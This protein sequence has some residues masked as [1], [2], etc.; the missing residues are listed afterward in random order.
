MGLPV[1]VVGAG[2][3][4]LPAATA[5]AENGIDVLVF[6][7]GKHVSPTSYPTDQFNYE[8]LASPWLST[9]SEWAGPSPVQRGIGIGGSTLFF[10]AVSQ[11]PSD[12]VL[13]SW[14]VDV[15]QIHR[16]VAAVSEFIRISGDTQPE[17]PLNPVSQHLYDSAQ[18]AGWRVRKAPVAILSKPHN[19]RPSCNYCGLCVYGCRPGDKSSV[20]QTW[21]PRASRT[22]RVQVITDAKVE[23]LELADSQQVK[24]LKVTIQGK[25]RT[26]P[27]SAVVLAAG[28]M[29]TPYLLKNS[30]QST[31]PNGIGNQHVGRNL[32][33]SI[34]HSLLL[35]FDQ[36]LRGG[37]AG[38]PVDMIVEEFA[39]RGILLCQGRNLAGITGPVS[40]AKFYTST[41]GLLGVREWMRS[42][43]P[44]LAGIGGYADS[45]VAYDDGITTQ[46]QKKEF[47][48]PLRD[49]DKALLKEMRK[50]LFQWSDH[51]KAKV[52]WESGSFRQPFVGAM[53]RGTCVLGQDPTN[54]AVGPTG[55]LHGYKNIAVCD[56][57]ILGKGL[58][59]N[60]SLPIQVL[61]YYIGSQLAERLQAA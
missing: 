6:E 28:A 8:L 13:E 16:H 48:K 52:L 25:I 36:G 3:G 35:Q 55:L 47:S 9:A 37:Y 18:Q 22:G 2:A 20:D 57:S 41:Q 61:S 44:R 34:W 21:L 58:I 10:Q 43:Y 39:N 59:A 38:I 45:S 32:I 12:K 4:G 5:L 51:A 24:A 56:A 19:G 49:K 26:V 29:E 30:R 50:Y 15:K 17:H 54:S 60:P 1:A 11:M 33:G 23:F 53:Y 31:A 7:Q 42:Y 46:T 27:V 40:A 14:G